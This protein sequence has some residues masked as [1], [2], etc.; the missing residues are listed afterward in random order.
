MQQGDDMCCTIR[1]ASHA[2][3]GG[4][5]HVARETWRVT[6]AASVA[7]HNQR[8]I[9]ERSYAP[10]ALAEAIDAG[11]SWFYVAVG[12]SGVIGFAQFLRRIDGQGELAR[13][14]ILPGCQRR[15]IGR[16]LL[17]AGTEAMQAAGLS[18]C[19]V[20]V[21]ADNAPAITFYQRLG[22]RRRRE[23]ANFLGDQIVRLVELQAH[24]PDLRIHADQ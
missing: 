12:A 23:H 14:Y 21:E 20:S 3:I 9:L 6:Y 11:S 13:I 24:L 15:G 22:F 10:E 4:I 18:R 1:L 19:Y 16:A 8:Q 2:D 17:S 5:C 7:V